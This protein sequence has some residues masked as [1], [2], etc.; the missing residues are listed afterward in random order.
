[1]HS[2]LSL[3][4]NIYPESNF[5]VN[6]SHGFED[7]NSANN[8]KMTLKGAITMLLEVEGSGALVLCTPTHRYLSNCH[9]LREYVKRFWGYAQK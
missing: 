7:I 5:E 3:L 2:T 4:I 8:Y 6:I 9:V 1:M